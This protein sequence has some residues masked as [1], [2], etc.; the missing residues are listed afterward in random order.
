MEL[1]LP[2]SFHISSATNKLIDD[3][4]GLAQRVNEFRPFASELVA[5]VHEKLFAERV[6]SSNAIEGNTLTLRETVEVLKTGHITGRRKREGTEAR[7][8]GDAV[9]HLE[10]VLLKDDSPY[11]PGKLLHL[12]GILLKDIVPEA[13][14]FR[15]DRRIITGA[16][17]QPPR[18]ELIPELVYGL[19]RA[20]ASG[21]D[22][23]SV[24]M[25]TWAHWALARVHPF[26]DGNG[27]MARLW[28]D[29][30]LLRARLAPAIIRLQDRDQNGYYDAL[31]AADAGDINLLA[32]LV[33]QRVASTLE[34]YIAAQQQSAELTDW[35][36]RIAGEA[37]VRAAEQRKANYLRWSRVMESLRNVFQRCAAKITSS[38]IEVQFRAYPLIDEVAWENI[39]SG[40]GSRQTWFFSLS[41]QKDGCRIR[42]YFFFGKHF[43]TPLDNDHE[44]SEP[45]VALL[46]SAQSGADDARMLGDIAECPLSLRELFAVDSD[47]VALKCTPASTGEPIA[48]YDRESSQVKLAQ[49]FIEQVLFRRIL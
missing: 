21:S 42:Y 12:H 26:V 1:L 9:K 30:V 11:M 31:S 6:Y 47:I 38:G 44:R 3:V 48:A 28:Q 27:R 46:I 49:E 41:F 16:T 2:Q 13:G 36:S 45:R 34:Q 40:I 39:R 22:I 7:N 19:L 10:S 32:Q 8:L 25:A 18:S 20:I 17:Y 23:H 4:D 29:M 15:T 37:A 35:A 33:A 24:V 14:A 43:W 5:A